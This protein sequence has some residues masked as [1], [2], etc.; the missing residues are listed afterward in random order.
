MNTHTNPIRTL[1]VD[2]SSNECALLAAEL[3]SVKAVKLIGFV[4]DGIEAIYYL[5]GIEQFKN[6][7]VFPFPDLLLLD[8]N[9]PR[10]DGM[11]VLKFLRRRSHR[12]Q[13]VLWSTT[14]ERVDIPL[15][16]HLGADLVCRKPESKRDLMA[17][18]H[19]VEGRGFKEGMTLPRS[20]KAS[21]VCCANV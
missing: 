7:D 6:R 2:D 12:P 17:I 18:I 13:V 1:V 19:R 14:L 5:R 4:H 8:F 16:L 11:G 9:M 15:A 20:K 21:A 10:C 3:H